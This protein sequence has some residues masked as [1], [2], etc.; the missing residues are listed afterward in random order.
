MLCTV[1]GILPVAD[2]AEGNYGCMSYMRLH[3][4]T[5]IARVSF[6]LCHLT[7]TTTRIDTQGPEMTVK[8]SLQI[9]QTTP[10]NTA[11]TL[12]TVVHTLQD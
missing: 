9:L 2:K 7:V 3:K 11:Y 12:D 4:F 8:E 10:K 5:E 6:G 1:V